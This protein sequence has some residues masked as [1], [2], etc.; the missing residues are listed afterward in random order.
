MT[1]SPPTLVFTDAEETVALARI[2]VY[3]LI[4]ALT[5]TPI[6]RDVYADLTAFLEDFGWRAC[7]A[8]D[9]VRAT[10]PAAQ[11]DRIVELLAGTDHDPRRSW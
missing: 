8:L 5:A 7:D 10:G 3:R 6:D 4:D 2:R 9:D 11:A 1:V